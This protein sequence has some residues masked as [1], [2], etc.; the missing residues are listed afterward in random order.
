MNTLPSYTLEL[1]AVD[2]RRRLQSSLAELRSRVHGRLPSYSKS[3]EVRHAS[4]L[5]GVV[6]LLVVLLGYGIARYFS[7]A[8]RR[9]KLTSVSN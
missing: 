6:G 8:H 7:S 1:R 2:Q 4:I 3:I 5:S 9:R